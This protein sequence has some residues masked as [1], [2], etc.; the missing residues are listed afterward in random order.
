MEEFQRDSTLKPKVE[1]TGFYLGLTSQNKANQPKTKANQPN[2]PNQ[3]KA[4]QP[5]Q[6]KAILL[7]RIGIISYFGNQEI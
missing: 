3:T 4:K 5:S 2:Q 6:T 7:K 1:T